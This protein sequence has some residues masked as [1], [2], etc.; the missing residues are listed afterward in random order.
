MLSGDLNITLN[1]E[2]QRGVSFILLLPIFLIFF[3]G[4]TAETEPPS[5][6]PRT[7][8]ILNNY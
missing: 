4:S 1:I 7:K 3:I 5:I 2:A 8:L 6:C